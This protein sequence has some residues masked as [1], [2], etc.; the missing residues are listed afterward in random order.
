MSNLKKIIW[1]GGYSYLLMPITLGTNIFLRRWL[2][3]YEVG[4]INIL[5]LLSTYSLYSNIGLLSRAEIQLPFLN[6]SLRNND[7]DEL[8]FYAYKASLFGGWVYSAIVVAIYYFFYKEIHPKIEIPLIIYCAYIAYYQ[9]AS[10]YITKHRTNGNFIF[11][12][13]Y[14]FI[15]SASSNLS[16]LI[17]SYVWGG[18]GYVIFATGLMALQVKYLKQTTPKIK[19]LKFDF[20]KFFHQI[21]LSRQVLLFGFSALLIRNFDGIIVGAILGPK[22]LGLYSLAIIGVTIIYSITNSVGNVLFP[23]LQNSLAKDCGNSGC[24]AYQKYITAPLIAMALILPLGIGVLY[25]MIPLL[26]EWIAPTFIPGIRAFQILIWGAY[27][28]SLMNILM[29]YFNSSGKQ[30]EVLK[31]HLVSIL[32]S[33]TSVGLLRGGGINIVDIAFATAFCYAAAYCFMFFKYASA[34]IK[35]QQFYKIGFV[36]LLPPCAALLNIKAVDYLF[37]EYRH[38][39]DGYGLLM[40]VLFGLVS[41]AEICLFLILSPDIK[42]NLKFIRSI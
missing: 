9:L 3:P 14:Q 8:D 34:C 22:D 4:M 40:L 20:K 11:L 7:Y 37:T 36:T 13:K 1:Y 28:F 42:N 27:Y 6:G 29:S 21:K 41:M 5:I 10:Y 15:V 33:V 31:I 30:L 25:Y 26:I 18:L 39:S 38:A 16:I 2:D 19:I 17:G 35:R 24:S 32:F 12:A 23:S